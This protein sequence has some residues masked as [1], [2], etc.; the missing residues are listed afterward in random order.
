MV[1]EAS[2][3]GTWD[4]ER[5]VRLADMTG[6]ARLVQIGDSRQ[7]GAIA[8][9]RPFEDSQRAG[10]AT[11]HIT[12]NLRSRS[13]QM[14]G[15]VAAL[16]GKDLSTVFELLKPDTTEVAAGDVARAAAARWA[17]LPKETRDNTLLLTAGR[18]MRSEANQAVQA[19][20]KATGEIS[21]SAPASRC[22]TGSMPPARV[23]GF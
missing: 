4:M 20:L 11:A 13:D 17:A 19:E 2:Q 3:V 23:P 8:A 10:H 6:A 22:S 15:I 21:R 14:K 1:E 7:L 18:A 9:G 12:D 5:I 16:D